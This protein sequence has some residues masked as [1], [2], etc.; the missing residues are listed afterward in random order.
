[1]RDIPVIMLTMVDDPKRGFT[2]GAAEFSTKP[3]DRQRLASALRKYTCPHPPCPVLLVDGDRA[4]SAI[5]RTFLEQEGWKV[6]EAENARVALDCMEKVRPNLILLDL[7]RLES[8][9]YKFVER[10][11]LRLEWRSIPIVLLA[12]RKLNTEER[13]RLGGSVET[14]L[15]KATT[16]RETL[17][18]E[19]HR[20]VENRDSSLESKD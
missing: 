6:C 20:L 4:T 8:E 19:V 14:I 11:R 16:S 17:L 7:T 2:L 3:V 1:M 9:G 5:T 10:V 13:S 15:Y 12:C 18:E